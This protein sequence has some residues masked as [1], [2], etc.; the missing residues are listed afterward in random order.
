MPLRRILLKCY[1]QTAAEVSETVGEVLD[2]QAME[3]AAEAAEATAAPAEE[4][5]A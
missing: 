2:E 4:A 3:A 5:Q 1:I